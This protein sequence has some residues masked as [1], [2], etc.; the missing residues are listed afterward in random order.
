MPQADTLL[1]FDYSGTLS[2]EMPR[3]ARP[4]N[5]RRALAETGLATLG[6]TGSEVFWE[7]IVNPTW[8]EG[9]TTQRGYKRV[10]AERIAA[11]GL[12]PGA[13]AGEIAAAASRFVESYLDRS[14]I[15]PDWHPLLAR[16]GENPEVGVIVATDH[17]PEATGRII[18]ELGA[19]GIPAVRVG[20]TQACETPVSREAAPQNGLPC[21]RPF[22]VANSADLGTWKADLVFWETVKTKLRQDKAERLVVVDDFG[23]NEAAG[24]SYGGEPA[25]I[26]VRKERTRETLRQV[27]QVEAEII[28]FFLERERTGY[29]AESARLIA[30][31][32]FR[33]ERFLKRH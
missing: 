22:F 14:R 16:L 27:F 15:A 23:F 32:A 10:M 8:V 2:L 7:G 21:R 24:D 9:S 29:E 3:F 13:S 1:I 17:Y 19:W 28:P 31:T 18:A 30:E 11:L 26:A 20:E 12:A 25:K 6:I 33:V 4:E 5:L